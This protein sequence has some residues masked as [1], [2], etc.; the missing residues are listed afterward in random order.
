MRASTR[1]VADVRNR[2]LIYPNQ[3]WTMRP[4]DSLVRI[5]RLEASKAARGRK[6][7]ASLTFPGLSC[8][9][10]ARAGAKLGNKFGSARP[11]DSFLLPVAPTVAARDG[12]V[13]STP[14]VANAALNA[15]C[16]SVSIGYPLSLRLNGVRQLVSS[17]P[18]A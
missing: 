18:S 10:A 2:L 3:A 6:T 17:P 12:C 11:V 7:R 15:A 8:K 4:G 14:N 5:A 9:L 13:Y 16:I 1:Y